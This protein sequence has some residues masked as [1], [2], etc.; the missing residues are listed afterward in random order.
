MILNITAEHIKRS[1]ELLRE[2]CGNICT[3]CP[4]ALAF[5]EQTGQ[6][7]ITVTTSSIAT[8]DYKTLY[9]CSDALVKQISHY[10][11]KEGY[12]FVAGQYELINAEEANKQ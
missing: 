11:A 6:E 7:N 9:Y 3:M 12:P 4:T 8:H 1:R 10:Y 5:K 2:K